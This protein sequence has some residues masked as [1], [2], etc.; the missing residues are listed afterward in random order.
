[1]SEFIEWKSMQPLQE[2]WHGFL[3]DERICAVIPWV[4]EQA[5]LP[6]QLQNLR[7]DLVKG[8]PVVAARTSDEAKHLA[9][10]GVAMFLVRAKLVPATDEQLDAVIPSYRNR[11][12]EQDRSR[13]LRETGWWEPIDPAAD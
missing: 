9:E 4:T 10:M 11:E 3:G 13:W 1:M 12:N 5:R 2:G 8:A 6:W 7:P